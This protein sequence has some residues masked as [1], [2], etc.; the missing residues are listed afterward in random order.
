VG[1]I[2]GFGGAARVLSERYRLS[3]GTA[4]LAARAL[5]VCGLIGGTAGTLYQKRFCAH[6]K[7]VLGET[8]LPEAALTPRPTARFAR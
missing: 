2:L 4:E 8:D 1:F 6:A 7:G 3:A 5:A